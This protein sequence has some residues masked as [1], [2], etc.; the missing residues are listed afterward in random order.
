[1]ISRNGD[2]PASAASPVSESMVVKAR[3]VMINGLLLIG[4]FTPKGPWANLPQE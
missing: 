4:A 3:R 1:V 2:K